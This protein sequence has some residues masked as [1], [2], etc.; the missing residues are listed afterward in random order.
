MRPFPDQPDCQSKLSSGL[1]MAIL[2][3]SKDNSVVLADKDDDND[4]LQLSL[5]DSEIRYLQFLLHN[6]IQ[7]KCGEIT[8]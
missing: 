8:N 3:E 5:N 6:Q 1:I 2:V 7:K 4:S